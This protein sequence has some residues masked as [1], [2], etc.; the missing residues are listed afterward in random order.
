MTLTR[1]N[2]VLDINL[3]DRM[4]LVEPGV[5]NAQLAKMLSGTGLHFSPDPASL[6][7]ATIGGNA[8]TNAGGPHSLRYG[9][10]P[11]TCWESKRS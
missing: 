4:A 1:M 3:R 8:A 9:Q 5:R 10:P 11:A 2:R 7:A 6:N